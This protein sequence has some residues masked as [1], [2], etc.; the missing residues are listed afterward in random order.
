MLFLIRHPV[1]PLDT[2]I[3]ISIKAGIVFLFHRTP[4]TWISERTNLVGILISE[5]LLKSGQESAIVGYK[6][7][8]TMYCINLN[9][10]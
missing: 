9:R 7:G 1:L 10:C 5:T 3:V 4:L 2:V 6:Q 8:H